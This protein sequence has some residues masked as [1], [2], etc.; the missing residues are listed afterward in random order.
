MR[1]E[2]NTNAAACRTLT[3]SGENSFWLRWHTADPSAE[4][5]SEGSNHSPVQKES[6]AGLLVST[7]AK[8]QQ[9]NRTKRGQ[10][11]GK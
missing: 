11:G 7:G 3:L 8:N 6:L 4:C 2:K 10:K 9:E 5:R 1:G